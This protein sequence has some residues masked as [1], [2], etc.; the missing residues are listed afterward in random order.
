MPYKKHPLLEKDVLKL[1]LSRRTKAKIVAAAFDT[2]QQLLRVP[3]NKWER[4][5]DCFFKEEEQ[6]IV[7]FLKKHKLDHRLKR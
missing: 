1:P 5:I 4:Y 6:E 7:D 3:V 2:L